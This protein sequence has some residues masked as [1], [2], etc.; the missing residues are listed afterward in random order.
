MSLFK[1]F[2]LKYQTFNLLQ[3]LIVVNVVVFLFLRIID[4]LF[5]VSSMAYLMLPDGFS[6]VLY[7]PWTLLTHMFIHADISHIFFN[8]LILYMASTAFV[9]LLPDKKALNVYFM[10]GLFGAALYIISF[11]IFPVFKGVE[12]YALGASA[13]VMA[14]VAFLGKFSPEKE[15]RLIFFNIKLWQLA[16]SL[17]IV[18]LLRIPGL[19]SGGHIAHLGGALLGYIYASQLKKGNDIGSGFEGLMNTVASWFKPKPAKMKTV[20]RSQKRA[21]GKTVYQKERLK[22][23]QVD[24]ILDKISKSG[25]ESL[26]KEEKDFLFQ[27]GK[28]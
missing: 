14:L 5:K 11:N 19:N 21:N 2:K 27:A 8:M 25:Y 3:K 26:S 15:I 6:E 10:G 23:E 7:R 17:I 24:A 9:D 16:V 18:D 1:D 12:G 22:Q 20:H 28:E 4:F 13:A